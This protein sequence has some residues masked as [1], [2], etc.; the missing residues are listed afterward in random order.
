MGRLKEVLVKA[1][2]LFLL[3]SVL[4]AFAIPVLLLVPPASDTATVGSTFSVTLDI[5][6]VTNLNSWQAD[7][8]YTP[9]LLSLVS[10]QE[11]P[12][13][14]SAG[15]TFF[16][17]G[18]ND[19]TNGD[20]ANNADTL[21]GAAAVFGNGELLTLTFKAIA[22]GFA[23]FLPSNIIL[24]DPNFSQIPSIP[25]GTFVDLTPPGVGSGLA[26]EPASFGLMGA[27]SALFL[28]LWLR[29]KTSVT[30]CV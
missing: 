17:P 18:T 29:R 13:L 21:I 6:G 15:S 22:P 28:L 5:D 27:S 11:G 3:S 14:S 12:F 30:R 1:I 20:L 19:P 8:F 9:S 25:I 24:L 2:F 16:I 7:I 23:S 4:P 26:P 10:V